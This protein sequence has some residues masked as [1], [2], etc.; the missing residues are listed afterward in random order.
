MTIPYAA[1]ESTCYAYF[2]SCL[3]EIVD[4]PLIDQELRTLF[5][6]FYNFVKNDVELGFL[7]KNKSENLT[8]FA[9]DELERTKSIKISDQD[10]QANLIYYR[11]KQAYLDLV[12]KIFNEKTGQIESKRTTKKIK[13]LTPD[14]HTSKIKSSIRANWIHFMDANFLRRVSIKL[15]KP[16]LTVHDCFLIDFLSIPDLIIAANEVMEE[17]VCAT[18]K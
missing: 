15:N 2:C 5:K 4:E 18:D 8:A 10:T 17:R 9:L 12:Y 7:Y 16:F 13:K 11:L 6:L 1:K 14:I 3:K